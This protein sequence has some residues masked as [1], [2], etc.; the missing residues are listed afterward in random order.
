MKSRK[1]VIVDSK[2]F[3]AFITFVLL[4]FSLVLTLIFTFSKAHSS[5]YNQEYKE[6]HVVTGDSLWDISLR[7]MPEDYDVREMIYNIK[8]LNNMETS[9]IYHGDTIK[10]P[11]YNN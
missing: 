9:E 1:Y 7:N 6:Y 5:S 11:I 8:K 4:I 3:F 2:R 10:I